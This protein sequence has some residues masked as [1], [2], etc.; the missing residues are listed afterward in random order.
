MST[1]RKYL[2]RHNDL[3]HAGLLLRSRGYFMPGTDKTTP[4]IIEAILIFMAKSK[5]T[6]NR[7]YMAMYDITSNRIRRLVAKYLEEKGFVRIQRSVYLANLNTKQ[8]TS[9]AQDILEMNAMYENND[10]I[11]FMPIN[12][13][14]LAESRF[15]GRELDFQLA[16][17]PPSSLVL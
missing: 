15:I 8:Y 7:T 13:G 9:V 1:P 4:Q 11:I 2:E 17:N 12:D 14:V 16:T 3:K 10:S 6:H 5:S